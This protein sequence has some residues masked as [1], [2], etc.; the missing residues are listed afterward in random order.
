MTNPTRELRPGTWVR[1]QPDGVD[2]YVPRPPADGLVLY[3]EDHLPPVDATRPVDAFTAIQL[4]LWAML[5]A[6]RPRS[7]DLARWLQGEGERSR[8]LEFQRI[9]LDWP[10]AEEDA[11]PTP[12]VTVMQGGEALYDQNDINPDN[13]LVEDS[14]DVY[15]EGT[16][17]KLSSYLRVSVELLVMTATK[18]DRAG[19]RRAF[20]DAFLIEP[21]DDRPG[22][23]V[24]VPAYYG[25][26]A[27]YQLLGQIYRDDPETAQANQWIL[28][29]QLAAEIPV[30]SL[31]P[32]PAGMR[33]N[34]GAVV[35][36]PSGS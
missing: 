2:K 16:V 29:A 23:R 11:I 34:L 31:V 17:L 35:T 32:A 28:T 22:R 18:D 19:V 7:F 36:G 12:S 4:G 27:R 30:V 8:E 9:F 24:I 3:S 21:D 6:M 20:E 1:R 15:D 13:R 5:S 26:S 25:R 10:R 14:L 33:P